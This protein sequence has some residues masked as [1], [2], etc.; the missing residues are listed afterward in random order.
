MVR[1]SRR[2]LDHKCI[3]FDESSLKIIKICKFVNLQLP[4]WIQRIFSGDSYQS[5][6]A[7]LLS[8]IKLEKFWV[9]KK[10][11]NSRIVSDNLSLMPHK[12]C[13]VSQSGH[14]KSGFWKWWVVICGE[15]SSHFHLNLQ[16][17]CCVCFSMVRNPYWGF[18]WDSNIQLS[19]DF[20]DP[21]VRHGS[22]M[23]RICL[24]SG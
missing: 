16:T 24:E 18:W 5:T 19:S 8:A 17:A 20:H 22:N 10:L 2:P 12:V 13:V 21:L 1:L 3:S 11:P 23:V 4:L 14:F 7:N 15:S 6:L 9:N